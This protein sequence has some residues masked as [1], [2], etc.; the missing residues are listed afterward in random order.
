MGK[1]NTSIG[2]RM[3]NYEMRNRSYAQRRSSVVIRIDGKAF[4][5]YTRGLAKPFDTELFDDMAET[6]KYLCENIQGAKM[7]YMQSDE[8]SVLLTDYDDIKTDAWFDYEIE[9]MT[10]VSASLAT[11]KFLHQRVK[12]LLNC[13][14]VPSA[15]A[16]IDSVFKMRLPSFDSRVFAMPNDEEVV[17]CFLWRQQDAERNS[18]QALAQSVFSH[19][20]LHGKN[21]SQMQDMLHERGINWNDCPTRQK[22]GVAVLKRQVYMTFGSPPQSVM[23]SEWQIDN[24]MPIVSKDRDY[25]RRLLPPRC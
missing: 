20:Q 14:A 16:V 12:R 6:A 21:N 25:V 17:N 23:R 13:G 11:T 5:T 7:A 8:I 22:R 3:K 24:E 10:S 15:S 4:H 18:I 19:K 2:D 9:K 1:D